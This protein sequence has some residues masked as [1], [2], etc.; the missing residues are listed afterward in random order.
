[1]IRLGHNP[2]ALTPQER[3][4][5]VP[6]AIHGAVSLPHNSIAIENARQ[7][8]AAISIPHGAWL[9]DDKP[10][11]TVAK[12]ATFL[13]CSESWVRRHL[14]EL[15]HTRR[16][17]LIRIDGQ[18]VKS[19]IEDRKSLE[20]T[21][22]LMPN[23]RYQRGG[24]YLRGKRKD[25]W[26]GTYRIDT[27]EGRQPLNIRLGTK[28]ELATKSA[29]RERLN[30]LIA[31]MNKP[32]APPPIAK[33]MRYSDMAAKWEKSEGPAL[34]ESTMD[35][36]SNALRAYVLP[37]WKD[38]RIDSIQREDI[39][40]FLNSQAAKY[41]R[42][43]LKS[44]RLV[45][46]MTLAWTEKNGYIKRPTGWLDGIRLPR[47]TGGRKVVRTELE[48]SQTLGIVQHLKEPYATLV[49]FLGLCGRRIEEA[50]GIKPTDLDENNV[51]HIRRIIYKGR[52]EALEEEQLL[53]LDQPEHAELVRRLRSLGEGH[54]WVFH[55]RK[56]TPISPGNARRRYLHPA[57]QAVGVKIG[58]WHDFR[59]TLIRKM[60]RGGVH[61]VVVSA[62][63]GH[64][65]VELA[66]EVYDRA[67]QN[68]IRAALCV[69]GRDLLPTGSKL[70]SANSANVGSD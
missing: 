12:A 68:D 69:V 56:G 7:S 40:N 43:S 49:L 53:P 10:L 48:P 64:K 61:P 29:A 57:A 11:M 21:R 5:V 55:S 14:T 33:S 59:H 52:A 67:N 36:Y 47:K 3:G 58:G 15:P 39:S 30:E 32:D 6:D 35:H 34:G 45:L 27:P 54:E 22:R 65:R 60:R 25:T 66:P 23:N 50:I 24:V 17:R 8:G 20:P 16:G 2:D 9:D 4:S 19:R 13:N 31:E 46:C 28:R 62:V 51:L 37:T 18:Q 41:S 63:V 44:M 70:G 42:S 26:Y 1:M 38:Y